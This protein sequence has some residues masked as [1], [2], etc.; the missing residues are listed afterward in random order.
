[1]VAY[2]YTVW[3]SYFVKKMVTSPTSNFHKLS[4]ISHV[5][6]Y[7]LSFLGVLAIGL[8]F[9]FGLSVLNIFTFIFVVNFN[10]RNRDERF[11]NFWRLC[12]MLASSFTTYMH[13]SFCVSANES[14]FINKIK[15]KLL[16][17]SKLSYLFHRSSISFSNT[18]C[19]LYSL[20]YMSWQGLY[21]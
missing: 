15:C 14:P 2:L 4:I 12:S 8:T 17:H 9:G 3:F 19:S 7:L 6:T 1:M 21:L 11:Q 20:G 16:R 10:M 18:V 5:V 13:L